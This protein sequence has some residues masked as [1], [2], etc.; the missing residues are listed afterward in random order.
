MNL[1]TKWFNPLSDEFIFKV[2]FNNVKSLLDLFD[3][4]TDNFIFGGVFKDI[5]NIFSNI[6]ELLSYI[7]PFSENF[8]AYKLV[9][10]LW[11]GFK[12]VMR[13]LFVPSEERITGLQNT[14]TSKFDFIESLKIAINSF[15]DII[16]NMGNAPVLHLTLG[17]TKYTPEMKDVKIIDLNWYKPYKK[18]GDL[19]ITAVM[20]AFFLIR[21]FGR[22]P[23]IISGSG[24]GI[25]ALES[26]E[27]SEK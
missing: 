3:V 5:S 24:S 11:D 15:K 4:N 18:Y 13:F 25:S 27:R 23:S 21:L 16:S 14:V 2:L 20:Y 22:L 7:N 19:V 17:S 9:D 26:I 12:S 10:L 8:F 1:I 6:G